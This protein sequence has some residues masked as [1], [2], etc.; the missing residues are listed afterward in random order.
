MTRRKPTWQKGS[1]YNTHK[2]L[3]ARRLIYLS[4]IFNQQ[5]ASSPLRPCNCCHPP[6]SEISRSDQLPESWNDKDGTHEIP[7]WRNQVRYF[8]NERHI[9]EN[10]RGSQSDSRSCCERWSGDPWKVHD[11]LRRDA[12]KH[13]TSNRTFRLR[14]LM[15]SSDFSEG[16][17]TSVEGQ[18]AQK[19][20]WDALVEVLE[21]IR[22]GVTKF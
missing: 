18:K 12:V 14:K 15:I 2:T 10:P 11:Q 3:P 1:K 22:S 19:A 21:G 5:I 7:S 17:T 13:P 4:Q 20:T 16:F 8:C 6:R 9:W